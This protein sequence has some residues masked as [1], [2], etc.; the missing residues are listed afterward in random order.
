MG[1]VKGGLPSSKKNQK[2]NIEDQSNMV[3][4]GIIS[5]KSLR[6]ISHIIKVRVSLLYR[7]PDTFSSP[8]VLISTH[9]HSNKCYVSQSISKP[10]LT[11]TL[12]KSPSD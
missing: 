2:Y 12:K 11:Y 1:K 4:G 3:D 10:N 6:H 7:G 8:I 9:D 5:E